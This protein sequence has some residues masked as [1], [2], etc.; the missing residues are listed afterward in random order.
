MK[1]YLAGAW[2]RKAEIAAIAEELNKIPGIIVDARWLFEEV[3]VEYNEAFRRE[4][5]RMDVEDVRAADILVRFTDDLTKPTVPSGLAT[6]ARMFEMGLAY[7]MN[8][9]II[10]VGGHQPIFDYLPEIQ[11]LLNVNRLKVVLKHLSDVNLSKFRA[12]VG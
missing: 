9:P 4:R 11:H 10:V 1:L 5:A 12:E 8:K 2:S 6:G 3:P 7:Q